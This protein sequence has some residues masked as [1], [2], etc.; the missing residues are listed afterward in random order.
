MLRFQ[1]NVG[2][3]AGGY[4]KS[5]AGTEVRRITGARTARTS[6]AISV[7]K[8]VVFIS[9]KNYLFAELNIRKLYIE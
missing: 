8:L 4:V 5:A 9:H 6:P 3:N 7:Q 1:F 2:K